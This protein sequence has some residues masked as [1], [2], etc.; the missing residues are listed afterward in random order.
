HLPMRWY[1]S[2]AGGQSEGPFEEEQL[3]AS[4]RAGHYRNAQVCRE[5][6]KK[7]ELASAHP[8]FATAMNTPLAPG[9]PPPPPPPPPQERKVGILLG[10]GVF[11]F[12]W[13]FSWFTLRKGHSTL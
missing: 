9:A 7:W 6:A 8:P 4:I 12:P 13:I 5:G 10:L 11:F 2:T 1:V 3:I